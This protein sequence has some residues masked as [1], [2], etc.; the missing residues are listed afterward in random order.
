MNQ[1]IEQFG[2]SIRNYWDT[3]SGKEK[4]LSAIFNYANS[5]PQR[6]KQEIKEV[7]F[8]K[9]LTPLAIV[10]EALSKDTDTWG[11]FYVDTLDNILEQAKVADKPQGV[12]NCLREFA[13][14]EKEEKPFVQKIADRLYKETNSNN[15]HIQLAA[16]SMLPSYLTNPSVKN[17]SVIK[18]ALLQ[19]L[20]DAHWKV[21]YIAFESLGYE[22]MLPAGHKLSL[23]DKI[24]KIIFGVPSY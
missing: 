7:L 19:K 6:F 20:Y 21:R 5:N 16:I 24:R 4:L 22:N 14:I 11:A 23:A 18:D 8:D 13:L 1:F 2:D 9:E 3:G 10:L 12:L 17:K 15:L